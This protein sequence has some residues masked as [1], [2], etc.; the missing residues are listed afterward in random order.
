MLLVEIW[1]QAAEGMPT[2]VSAGRPRLIARVLI[3]SRLDYTGRLQHDPV[4]TL[5]YLV[6]PQHS[7]RNHKFAPVQY[8]SAI[9]NSLCYGPRQ[10]AMYSSEHWPVVLLFIALVMSLLSDQSFGILPLFQLVVLLQIKKTQVFSLLVTKD[11]SYHLFHILSYL[12]SGAAL[13]NVKAQ[14]LCRT[15]HPQ[16]TRISI[17][18][19]HVKL[20]H[21][22]LRHAGWEVNHL[23]S[24]SWT[25]RRSNSSWGK[26]FIL[27]MLLPPKC[28]YM[29]CD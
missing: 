29:L 12:V 11:R 15:S 23:Q 24:H 8:N 2:S 28:L 7:W 19:T 20:R 3:S 27:W 10:C 6:G 5:Y 26:C 22:K 16:T 4:P 14:L 17:R 21:G 1:L 9:C 13:T 25:K 18:K